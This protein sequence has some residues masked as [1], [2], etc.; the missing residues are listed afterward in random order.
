[1]VTYKSDKIITSNPIEPS[2]KPISLVTAFNL[3]KE[4]KSIISDIISKSAIKKR[5]FGPNG[6]YLMRTEKKKEKKRMTWRKKKIT[7][8]RKGEKNLE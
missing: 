4:L 6:P 8:K 7:K 1:M 2:N 5:K 3:S